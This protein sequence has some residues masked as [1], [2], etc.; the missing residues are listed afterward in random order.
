MKK[1][2]GLLRGLCQGDTFRRLHNTEGIASHA[3]WT[4]L[5]TEVKNRGTSRKKKEI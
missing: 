3:C 4:S 1:A 5:E 2:N